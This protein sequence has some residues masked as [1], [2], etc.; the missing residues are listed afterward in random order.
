MAGIRRKVN[1]RVFDT[2]RP[3]KFLKKGDDLCG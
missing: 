3:P 1:S 2:K